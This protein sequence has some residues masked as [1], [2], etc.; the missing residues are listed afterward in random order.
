MALYN[1]LKQLNSAVGINLLSVGN[2]TLDDFFS[3]LGDKNSNA[4]LFVTF[5]KGKGLSG[6]LTVKNVFSRRQ[7]WFLLN[8]YLQRANRNDTSD[9]IKGNTNKFGL[10]TTTSNNDLLEFDMAGVAGYPNSSAYCKLQ[11]ISDNSTID[12]SGKPIFVKNYRL[13]GEITLDEVTNLYLVP[14][15]VISNGNPSISAEVD[16]GSSNDSVSCD[17]SVFIRL[18]TP[19]ADGCLV[20]DA[21][22][23]FVSV[24]FANL[25]LDNVSYVGP[26]S[27]FTSDDYVVF[28]TM[29]T[30]AT[31]TFSCKVNLDH[32]VTISSADPNAFLS[33]EVFDI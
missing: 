9:T 31:P 22:N 23:S 32:V 1:K 8:Q 18:N 26:G 5:L 25:S 17:D 19:L 15:A 10:F 14:F 30:A 11:E 29:S 13:V 21:A 24:T 28:L 27:P 3:S 6:N 4:G 12:E 33:F 2:K 7:Y 20:T 16:L